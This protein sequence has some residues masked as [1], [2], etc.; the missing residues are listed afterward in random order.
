VIASKTPWKGVR[1]KSLRYLSNEGAEASQ[2][3]SPLRCVFW[4]RRRNNASTK[5]SSNDIGESSALYVSTLIP[6]PSSMTELVLNPLDER[7]A[8][9]LGSN[10][11]QSELFTTETRSTQ[12][13]LAAPHFHTATTPG[14]ARR[15]P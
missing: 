14:G 6:G 9:R 11:D 1:K 3:P 12:G 13:P 15:D 2:I 10:L 8:N 7:S 5:M 4:Q